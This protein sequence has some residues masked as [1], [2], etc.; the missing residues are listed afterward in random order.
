MGMAFLHKCRTKHSVISR[1]GN[2]TQY[3][4]I[5]V[6]D[7]QQQTE[8]RVQTGPQP[9]NCVFS[10]GTLYYLIYGEVI[11]GS[12]ETEAAAVVAKKRT[13]TSSSF[14]SFS[15]FGR[16]LSSMSSWPRVEAGSVLPDFSNEY[17]VPS[18]GSRLRTVI[19]SAYDLATLKR[20]LGI[21][22]ATSLSI[23]GRIDFDTTSRLTTVASV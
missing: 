3:A 17:I 14:C 13:S 9:K 6:P 2:K 18:A 8:G 21:S 20:I 16:I 23:M 12:P 4:G 1:E 22:S 11:I 19:N 5:P 7:L 15:R 10:T